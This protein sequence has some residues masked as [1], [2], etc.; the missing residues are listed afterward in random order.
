MGSF[1]SNGNMVYG[2]VLL[3][4]MLGLFVERDEVKL[5]I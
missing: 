2:A 5:H 1:Q 4:D 3:G